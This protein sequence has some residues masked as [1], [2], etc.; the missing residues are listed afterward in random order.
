MGPAVDPRS[1]L[2]TALKVRDLD[3]LREPVAIAVGFHGPRD[4]AGLR[5]SAAALVDVAAGG[6]LVVVLKDDLARAF[7]RII[8]AEL[9]HAG[10]LVVIDGIEVGDLDYLDIGRPMGSTR[11]F[12]VTV[13]SLTLALRPAPELAVQGSHAHEH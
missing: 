4:Y 7:G 5:R 13:K 10:P 1:A 9:H 3:D 6:P 2:Q 8:D 12:P 11:S